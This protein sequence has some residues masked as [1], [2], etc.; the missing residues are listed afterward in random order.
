MTLFDDPDADYFNEEIIRRADRLFNLAE[1][2][3]ENETVRHRIEREHLSVKYM[4]AVYIADK[5]ERAI[6]A[7]KLYREVKD[8]RLTEIMERM[9]LE[10]SFRYMKNS[11]FA[12]DQPN[13]V[14]LYYIVR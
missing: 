1:R 7:D 10:D 9:H 14:T 13:R 3:A 8:F 5:D 12:K 2:A 11:R 4:K 6:A